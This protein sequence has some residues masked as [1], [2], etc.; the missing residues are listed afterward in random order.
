MESLSKENTAGEYIRTPD[1]R[2]R[3]FISSTM[4]EL[5]EERQVVK[6]RIEGLHLTPVLFELGA[7]PHPPRELYR[8]YLL[9]SHIFVGI[10]WQRYGWIAPDMDISGLEDE[11]LLSAGMPRLI[12]IK[13]PAPEREP[14]LASLLQRIESEASACYKRFTTAQEL[15]ELVASDLILFLSERFETAARRDIPEPQPV[16]QPLTNLPAELTPFIG[17]EDELRAVGHLFHRQNIRLVTLTGPGGVG[18]TRLA[19]K[20]ASGLSELFTDGIWLVELAGLADPALLAQAVARALGIRPEQGQ[21]P[22]NTLLDHLADKTLLLILDNCEHL[23]AQAAE[24]A[25][26]ILRRAKNVRLLVTSREPLGATGEM[27]HQ[28]N[29][30]SIPDLG[31]N[32]GPAELMESEAVKL[33]VERACA[34][35]SNF[36]LTEENISAVAQICARLDGIPL[37][38]VLAAARTRALSVSDIAARLNDRFNLLV[39]H[40][41]AIPRQQTLKALFEWSY[42]LLSDDERLLLQR[43]SIFAGGWTLAAAGQVCTGGGIETSRVFDLL[44]QLVDKS[45]V[46]AE[47]G[48]Q[49]V[50]YRFLETIREFGKEYLANSGDLDSTGQRHAEYFAVLAGELAGALHDPKQELALQQLE[51]EHSNLILALEWFSNA[52]AHQRL[53]LHMAVSLWQYWHLR[54]AI[55]EGRI[56]LPRALDANPGAPAELRAQGLLCLAMLVFQQGDYH[57]AQELCQESLALFQS[58]Q[59]KPGIAQALSTL[60]QIAHNR[61]EYQRAVDLLNESLALRYEL[62]DQ[63]GIAATI[64]DLGII[65]RDQGKH[66]FA[67]DLMEESLRLSRQL[68]DRSLIASASNNLGIILYFLCQYSRARGLFAEAL[69]IYQDFN[70]HCGISDTLQLLGNVAKDQGEFQNAAQLFDECLILKDSLGDR[71]GI[72]QATTCLG[73]VAL[74][75]GKY[76]QAAELVEEGLSLYQKLGVKRGILFARGVLVYVA[77]FRGDLT[78]LARLAEQCLSLAAEIGAPRP[79]AYIRQALGLTAYNRG[80]YQQALELLREAQQAFEKIGDRRSLAGVWVNLARVA[81]RQGDRE[82]AIQYLIQSLAVSTQLGLRWV[83]AYTLEIM[84]LLHSS[85]GDDARAMDLFTQ[86]L[87]ISL[88]H[89]NQQGIANCLGAMAGIAARHGLALQALRCF[90]AAE[91]IR[92][93][94]GAAVGASDRQ[95]YERYLSMAQGQLEAVSYNTAWAAGQALGAELL[96]AG[97]QDAWRLRQSKIERFW[98]DYLATLP[99]AAPRPPQPPPAEAFGDSPTLADELAG[100]IAAGVKTATCSA[101]WEWQAGGEP[102][103]QPGYLSIVLDGQ[104]EPVCLIETMAVEIIPYDQVSPQFAHAEGEG[105]RSLEYWRAAHWRFFS[106]LLPR[107]GRQPDT[108]MPLVCE[109]FRVL[110]PPAQK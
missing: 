30:L 3:I 34:V 26:T 54:G 77:H 63:H 94:N 60:G 9:Q 59:D 95:E 28:V 88:D 32:P 101:L 107:I 18:K 38:I 24:L 64:G 68:N 70:D 47:V 12:Y 72:A 62:N 76:R 75:Q 33:F 98:G 21:E 2:L 106:R 25:E 100:L 51:T 109:R 49:R 42:N 10:Y 8:S 74:F 78:R 71:L 99:A 5:A 89:E 48:D 86:S 80:D 97:L 40:R 73:E 1:Q 93:D 105:D 17:R 96:A 44:A 102:L 110:Y 15:A 13:H 22:V 91:K 61:G 103:P 56:W 20:A 39:G 27:L 87:K 19:I 58:I 81:Y 65:A 50:R 52:P 36:V 4:G 43:L 35:R 31:R 85:Q 23:V 46:I 37:A 11:Y 104:G 6:S 67:I 83:A 108:D 53:F 79:D 29:P 41:T 84:G 82:S 92:A 66:D 45:M 7:R 57:Q 55:H 14:A 90:A 69:Q 16:A